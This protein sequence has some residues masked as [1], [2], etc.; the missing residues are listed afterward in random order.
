MGRCCNIYFTGSPYLAASGSAT[1]VRVVQFRIRNQQFVDDYGFYYYN[2][3]SSGW[4][5]FYIKTIF[6]PEHLLSRWTVTLSDER[7]EE[8]MDCAYLSRNGS[9]R[10]QGAQLAPDNNLLPPYIIHI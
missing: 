1:Q 7:C 9:R 8:R 2:E 5:G 3:A 4:E 6:L 10:A